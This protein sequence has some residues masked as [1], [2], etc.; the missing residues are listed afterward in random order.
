[1]KRLLLIEFQKLLKNRAS[2][3]L[4]I[5]YFILLSFIAL[6]ASIKFEFGA[7]RLHL[8]EQGIFNFPYIWHFNTYIAIWAKP[9]LATVI[10]SMIANEYTYG[11]LKQNL[12]DGMSKKEFIFS[13]LFTSILISF[14]S[15]LFIFLLSL[16]LGYFFSSYDEWGRIFSDLE[17]L[18]AYF[19]NLIGFFSFCIFIAVLI[20]RSA[21]SLGFIL[22]WFILEWI[23]YG[24]LGKYILKD[25]EIADKIFSFFPLESISNL[26]KQPF[27]RL[28][29]IKNIETTIT[30][31]KSI[32][33][34]SVHFSEIAIVCV[35]TFIFIY[36]SYYILRKRD[37]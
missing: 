35:W 21:F 33:D 24:I 29:V 3:F 23:I 1:M 34:Y 20:K 7:F 17:Y 10:V 19:F 13:K 2:K 22:L 28:S 27:D 16:I 9:F 8:A 15:T 4:I 11:T 32:R 12:I 14:L 5:S 26:L 30:G 25:F 18:A 36:L 6:I 31:E 37:L